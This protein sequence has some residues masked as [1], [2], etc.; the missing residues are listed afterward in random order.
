ML[1]RINEIYKGIHEVRILTADVAEERMP[2]YKM[3]LRY[4]KFLRFLDPLFRG[5]KFYQGIRRIEK[6][7]EFDVVLFGDAVG[8]ILP[9]LF[10]VKSNIIGMINDD[11]VVTLT[12]ANF[13]TRVGG[14]GL[15]LEKQFEKFST[16]CLDSI[17]VCSKYLKQCIC[18]TYNCSEK[19]VFRLYQGVAV[20]KIAFHPKTIERE[21]VLKIL[22]VKHLYY[23][24]GLAQLSKALKILTYY[25]FQLSILGPHLSQ[26]EAIMKMFEGLNHVQVKFYGP[27]VQ[28]DVYHNMS[29]HHILCIPSVLEALGLANVEGIAHGISVVSTREGGIPEV[30]DNGENGWLCESGSPESLANAIRDCIEA[31]P[32]ERLKKQIHG[33]RFVEK[34]FDNTVS[35][36]KLLTILESHS[37]NG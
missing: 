6:E 32:E 7:Y 12:I 36:K 4:P 14:K 26:K 5:W 25:H 10:L 11:H 35:I 27:I 33:R 19:K 34:N 24:G 31:S 1:L 9:K 13:L 15:L 28:K 20:N 23:Y 29:T 16:H 21:K 22:F 30:L 3:S 8:G 17:I 18:E 37:V 2:V